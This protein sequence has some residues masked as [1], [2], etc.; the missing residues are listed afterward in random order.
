MRAYRKHQQRVSELEQQQEM[1]RK[2][3]SQIG[4]SQV[5]F[6]QEVDNYLPPP[7]G[8]HAVVPRSPRMTG[9]SKPYS[10][11]ASYADTVYEGG[12]E[13]AAQEPERLRRKIREECAA[14]GQFPTLAIYCG[15]PEVDPLAHYRG[16]DA[17]P[18]SVLTLRHTRHML[19]DLD[20]GHQPRAGGRTRP[21]TAE[22][23]RNEMIQKTDEDGEDYLLWGRP[24][25]LRLGLGGHNAEEDAP[26]QK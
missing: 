8:A 7:A 14:E 5:R 24:Q 13:Q 3:L 25:R 18:S 16:S 4:M 19:E 1:L 9:G 23:E 10:A 20:S 6:R 21:Q 12:R 11:E 15:Q 2:S 26:A 22:T 17:P